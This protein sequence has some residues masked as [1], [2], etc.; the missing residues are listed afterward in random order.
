MDSP[1]PRPN[2]LFFLEEDLAED[3]GAALV[4]LALCLSLFF[5]LISIVIYSYGH[6]IK[7]EFYFI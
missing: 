7:C 3:V 2:F 6:G 4:E 1:S 5:H